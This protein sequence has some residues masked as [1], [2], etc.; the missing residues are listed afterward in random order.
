MSLEKKQTWKIM[1]DYSPDDQSVWVSEESIK[2]IL[3][4]AIV[5]GKD[6]KDYM[7]NCAIEY[8]KKEFGGEK[9]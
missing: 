2:R 3:D 4:D 9:E 8:L 5:E 6:D 1:K 7:W